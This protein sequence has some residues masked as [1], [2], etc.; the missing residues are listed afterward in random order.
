MTGGLV[1]LVAHGTQ[2]LFLTGIP[3]IT[4]FKVVYRKY[5][6]FSMESIYVPLSGTPNFDKQTITLI[7]KIGDLLSKI[8]LVVNIPEVSIQY[9]KYQSNELI[10][11]LDNNIKKYNIMLSNYSEY[12][13][14]NLFFLNKLKIA[15]K[16]TNCDWNKIYTI[17]QAEKIS[18]NAS[19]INSF[20]INIKNGNSIVEF[21]KK[22]PLSIKSQYIGNEINRLKLIN[23]INN[24]IKQMIT[25]YEKKEQEVFIIIKNLKQSKTEVE[26]TQAYFSWIDNLGFNL[27]NSCSVIIGGNNIANVD[28][29]FLNIYYKLNTLYKHSENLD[30]MIGNVVDLTN[31]DNKIKKSRTLYI[32]LPFWFTQH[33][34]NN[35]PLVS[36]L[37]HDI[38]FNV[39]FNSLDKC[40]F[41]NNPDINLSNLLSLGDCSLLVEYIYLDIDEKTKFSQFSHEYLIQDYQQIFTDD[42]NVNNYSLKME[43]FHPIKELYWIIKETQLTKKYKLNNLYYMPFIFEIN[44]IIKQLNG[45]IRIKINKKNDTNQYYFSN[46]YI[47]LKYTKYYDGKYKIINSGNDYIDIYT[48]FFDY[49][50]YYDNFYGIVYNDSDLNTFNP[51]NTQ[52]IQFN[53][54]DR[55]SKKI[56]SEYFNYVVP[57]Q[58]YNN[59]PSDGTNV[60]SFSLHPTEFQPSGTCNFSLIKNKTL[61]FDI[62]E[63]FTK[64]LKA[65]GLYYNLIMY[66]INYNI[67]RFHHGLVATVFS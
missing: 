56:T 17:L 49:A 9:D 27:I 21:E 4:F 7:P 32:P 36:M 59:T 12:F 39:Q 54:I 60:F 10:Q 40:C 46:S 64:Y 30:E 42:I 24:F 23:D 6:N 26:S 66:C 38:E 20:V 47:Y 18:Q 41:F 57:Y 55:T 3:Q 11:Q 8:Y 29:D 52:Y 50:D 35:L 25:I 2:D 58:Y 37:Y 61:I 34:G 53:G 19:K 48:D 43:F 45:I 67:L 44:D 16:I 22:F 13:K 1:Q 14:Y 65:N 33:N 15:I 62:K 5:T 63:L 31:Y 28:T 51:I